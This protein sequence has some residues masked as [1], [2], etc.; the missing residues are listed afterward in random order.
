MSSPAI[1][2][3]YA[4]TGHLVWRRA[5]QM[6]RDAEEA[7]TLYEL[8]QDHIIPTYYRTGPLGYSPEWVAMAKAAGAGVPTPISKLIERITGDTG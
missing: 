7:R 4:R 8:L 6:L 3:L 1:S 2:D 5:R